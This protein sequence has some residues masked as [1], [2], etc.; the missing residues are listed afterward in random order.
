MKIIKYPEPWLLA[1]S[2]THPTLGKTWGFFKSKNSLSSST[3]DA[4]AFMRRIGEF[5]TKCGL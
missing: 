5:V 1:I 2:T 3:Q 4:F